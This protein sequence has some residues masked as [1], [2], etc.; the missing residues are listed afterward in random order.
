MDKFTKAERLEMRITARLK[1]DIQKLA[2][3]DNRSLTNYIETLLSDHVVKR[4]G[5]AE[6]KLDAQAR[7]DRMGE[8]QDAQPA[9]P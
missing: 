4:M 7:R 2:A 1:A 5:Y 3:A 8:R 6:H 9:R